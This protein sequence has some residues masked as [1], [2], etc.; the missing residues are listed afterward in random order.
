MLSLIKEM[1]GNLG[2]HPTP[3]SVIE[4]SSC[5]QKPEGLFHRICHHLESDLG[6]SHSATTKKLWNLQAA[7]EAFQD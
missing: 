2:R 7:S 3:D 4:L 6:P 1:T 5:K